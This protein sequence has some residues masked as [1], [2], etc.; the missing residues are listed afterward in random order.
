MTVIM[1][2]NY[3]SAYSRHVYDFALSDLLRFQASNGVR[4]TDLERYVKNGNIRYAASLIEN[5]SAE[6]QRIR[7]I[8][9]ASTMANAPNG[10]TRGSASTPSRSRGP[11]TWAW[12]TR[13]PTSRSA[14]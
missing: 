2:R 7:S 6:N 13:W 9:R 1:Q 10:P 14:S 4:I 5:A 8:W 12:R 11:S 3:E